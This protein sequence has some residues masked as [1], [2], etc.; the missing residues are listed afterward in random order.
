[1]RIKFY[2]KYIILITTVI[3]F[4][5]IIQF[6][7][8]EFLCTDVYYHAKMAQ[9][10][11]DS[12]KLVEIFP[13]LQYTI[14]NDNF[15]EHHLLFHILLLPFFKLLEPFL[16][17]KIAT[18]IFSAAFFI[19]FFVILKKLNI[20]FP[21]FWTLLLLFSSSL[22]IFRLNLLRAQSLALILLLIGIYLLIKNNYI[23]LIPLTIF[24]AWLF[25]GFI[26]LGIV[27]AIKSL[28]EVYYLFKTKNTK[29]ISDLFY[30]IFC[31]LTG[32]VIAIILNPYFPKNI[33]H[34]FFHLY[35]VALKD[36]FSNMPVGIEWYMSAPRFLISSSL[37]IIALF[38]ISIF[39][40]LL[41]KIKHRKI[42]KITLFLFLNA[43]IF[44]ILTIV[45]RKMIEYSA[46]LIIL[47]AAYLYT[48]N[49]IAINKYIGK[50]FLFKN[51]YTS[52]L[53]I[54][55]LLTS[56]A[57]YNF[58]AVYFNLNNDKEDK[59]NIKKASI[60]MKE[61]IPANEIVYHLDWSESPQLL[62]YNDQNYYIAGLDPNFMKEYNYNLYQKWHQ[63]FS[64][65]SLENSYQIIKQDF[66]ADYVFINKDFSEFVDYAKKDF[67]FET[68]YENENILIYKLK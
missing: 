56:A 27:I 19:A 37:I 57:I 32:V 31:Y 58:Q 39:I 10:I 53:L 47:L 18:I 3:S 51:K 30:P 15:V 50:L 67:R 33:Y 65:Q 54:I 63:L 42:G 49:H 26:I 20:K 24:Y 21:H 64:Q 38:V 59:T 35:Q 1:M 34:L 41:T 45:V 12:G 14:L 6:K 44:F 62:F 25:D 7:A 17:A 36:P 43:V 55:F 68:I 29:L 2:L 46:P 61:N 52:K 22:F 13:W 60:W 40:I 11:L 4:I 5:A 48:N 28:I 16:A 8:Y 23:Y 66:K 9:L